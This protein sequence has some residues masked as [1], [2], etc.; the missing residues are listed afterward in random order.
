MDA[1]KLSPALALVF[2]LFA[3]HIPGACKKD[4]DCIPG[5]V[6]SR[7][8][9][10]KAGADGICVH[11]DKPPVIIHLNPRIIGFSPLEARFGEELIISGEDFS[12]V[13]S[14]NRVTLNDEP[15]EIRSATETEIKVVIPKSMRC[16]GPVRVTVGAKTATSGSLF[17]YVPTATVSTFVGGAQG[18]SDGKGSAAQ[19]NFPDGIAIDASGVLYVT[20]A[21]NNRIRMVT[22]DGE[23]STLASGFNSPWGLAI[24]AAGNLYIT[25]SMNHCIRRMDAGAS[26]TITTLAGSCGVNTRGDSDGTGGAAQFN[27]PDG[28]AIDVSGDFYVADSRN[29]RIRKVTQAGEVSTVVGSTPGFADSTENAAHFNYPNSVAIDFKTG[30]LYVADTWNN[31]IRKLTPDGS[32]STLAGSGPTGEDNGTYADGPGNEARFNFPHG[33]AIDERNDYLYVVDGYNNRIRMVTPAGWVSTLAG[34]ERGYADG[35]GRDARFYFPH[36]IVI[37]AQGTLYITDSSNHRIRKI[38]LE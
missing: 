37:D 11:E 7:D 38:V 15:A 13:P 35:K 1:Q 22:P 28:I 30:T 26:R 24:D 16:T 17:T 5:N 23:V 6:C 3:C 32:V 19:F 12:T 33:M 34:S 9:N 4:T 10:A 27:E 21:N 18:Y 2:G 29:N 8:E 20:D 14:E 36:G 25:D 31:R